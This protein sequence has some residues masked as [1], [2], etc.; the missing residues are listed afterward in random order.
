MFTPE[1]VI[2]DIL[3]ESYVC[4][5]MSA[6]SPLN[7][8]FF[9]FSI[10]SRFLLQMKFFFFFLIDH[11]IPKSQVTDCWVGGEKQYFFLSSAY[12]E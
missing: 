1:E 7:G 5:I 4:S 11:L 2:L 12:L 10:F 9:F 3:E 8:S 6:F